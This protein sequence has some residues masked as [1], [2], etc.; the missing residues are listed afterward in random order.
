M[1]RLSKNSARA[2]VCT[3]CTKRTPLLGESPSSVTRPIVVYTVVL[4]TWRL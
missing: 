1:A 3:P 4:K 2:N